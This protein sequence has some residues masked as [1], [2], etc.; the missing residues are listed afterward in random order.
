MSFKG[1]NS[2]YSYILILWLAV[3]QLS[4]SSPLIDQNSIRR[5][6]SAGSLSYLKIVDIS[7][8]RGE[9]FFNFVNAGNGLKNKYLDPEFKRTFNIATKSSLH[10]AADNFDSSVYKKV[11]NQFAQ[12]ELSLDELA[13]E[14]ASQG[15]LTESSL[16][17]VIGKILEKKS[18]SANS[19]KIGLEAVIIAPYLGLAS[20]S[21]ISVIINRD[22]YF[23]N[24]GYKAGGSKADVEK[25]VKSGRSF[26]SSPGHKA[27]D[28]SD[29][30]YLDEMENLLS[31]KTE[32]RTFYHSLLLILLA[33]DNSEYVRL[34]VPA[35]TVLTDFFSIYTAE[36]NRYA[37]TG[38]SNHAWQND[39]AEVTMLAAFSAA[40]GL[41]PGKN[42]LQKNRQHDFFAVGKNGSGLGETR[43]ARRGY[44]LVISQS[45]RQL[46]P[47]LAAKLEK[48]VGVK[49]G[50]DIFQ[51]VMKFV[52]TSANQNNIKINSK[53]LI[54][55]LTD[56]LVLAHDEADQINRSGIQNAYS[57]LKVRSVFY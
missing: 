51:A 13:E 7:D 56:Y 11:L 36:L 42:G 16:P 52:N 31:G 39:L 38:F 44:Q 55:S 46:H 1:R 43:S 48:L 10:Q 8:Y 34:S 9:S 35:Q 57:K 17:M 20:G 14:M 40:T 3:F 53:E 26:G 18:L 32:V 30:F 27:L 33:C 41:V 47:E 23:Y 29:V 37:M 24:Y 21:G 49:P 4:C 19:E 54:E 15:E 12:Q 45:M 25:D 22:N 28:T 2:F 6:S 5:P 50:V